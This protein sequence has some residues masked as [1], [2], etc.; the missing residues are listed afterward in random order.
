MK[1]DMLSNY[2]QST[3]DMDANLQYLTN[4]NGY[5]TV[6]SNVN[7]GGLYSAESISANDFYGSFGTTTNGVAAV[8]VSASANGT[9][10]T[11]ATNSDD[12]LSSS[13]SL[14][15]PS[16]TSSHSPKKSKTINAGFNNNNNN[17]S[18]GTTNNG[19][20][21]TGSSQ[22][23]LNSRPIIEQQS[24]GLNENCPIKADEHG[25]NNNSTI[26]CQE[27]SH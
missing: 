25:Y 8:S 22:S 10:Q 17:N 24:M 1:L 3:L 9:Q 13:S 12:Q 6:T 18:Y 19:I 7:A 4:G 16:S 26:N 2:V 20:Q 27:V 14:S 21:S 23:L 15:S 11:T 5:G